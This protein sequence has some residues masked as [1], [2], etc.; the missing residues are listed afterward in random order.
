MY[1]DILRRLRDAGRRK[2]PEKMENQQLVSPSR[3]YF[4]TAVGFGQGFF[5][6]QQKHCDN[7]G[8]SPILSLLCSN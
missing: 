8:A 6:F 7:T 5:F 2:L 4:S 3:Q 1:V